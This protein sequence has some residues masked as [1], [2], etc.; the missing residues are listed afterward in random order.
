LLSIGTK[1]YTDSAMGCVGIYLDAAPDM[2][3]L[4]KDTR[5]GYYASDV[6]NPNN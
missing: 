6:C 5:R 2:N 1:V 3:A 4:S